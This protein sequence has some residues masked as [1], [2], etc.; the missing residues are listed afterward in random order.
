MPRRMQHMAATSQVLQEVHRMDS[1]GVVVTSSE[2][3]QVVRGWSQQHRGVPLTTC[4]PT[5]CPAH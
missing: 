5:R 2:H 1:H 4:K 3:R